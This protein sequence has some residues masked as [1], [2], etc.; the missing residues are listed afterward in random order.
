MWGAEPTSGLRCINAGTPRT[1]TSVCDPRR[2]CM[3]PKNTCHVEIN[4]SI[5]HSWVKK[6]IS[7]FRTVAVANTE[8]FYSARHYCKYST[9]ISS[10][11][12]ASC[13]GSPHCEFLQSNC[14]GKTQNGE[15]WKSQDQNPESECSMKP[16]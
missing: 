9:C 5:W 4:H 6:T 12:F 13:L 8:A 3:S 7:Q 15:K 14:Q 10:L 1:D 16:L 11:I 2:L